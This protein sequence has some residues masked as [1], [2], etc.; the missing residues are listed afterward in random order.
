MKTFLPAIVLIA[1]V[2]GLAAHVAGNVHAHVSA[3]V[4]AIEQATK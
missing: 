1:A 4:A 3:H 2:M